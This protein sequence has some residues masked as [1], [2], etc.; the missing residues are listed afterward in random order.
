[1]RT[2]V[3][4]LRRAAIA[5][6]VATTAGFS[7]VSAHAAPADPH[8][9]G[10]TAV[11]QVGYRGYVFTV[12]TSWSVV[13]LTGA[14]HACVRFDRHV[15]YLGRPGAD[16]DCPGN[17]VGRTEALLVQPAVDGPGTGGAVAGRQA[18]EVDVAASRIDATATF[19]DDPALVLR[20][21]AGAGLPTA[22]PRAPGAVT[23]GRRSSVG[24]YAHASAPSAVPADA[25]NFTGKGFDACAAP[26]QAAMRAWTGASPYRAVGV[27]IGGS[28][29]ACDQPNLTA[30]WVRRQYNA[31]WRFL[32]LYVGEQASSISSAVDE[33]AAAADDAVAQARALG[34]G[35]GT[36]LYY[37]MEAYDPDCTANVLDF[38][39]AWTRELHAD[40]YHS[41]FYSSSH[42]GIDD[43]VAHSGDG[44]HTMPDVIF[45]ALW[46][47][48]ADTDDP[49]VPSGDWAGH[50]RVHQYHG[51]ISETWGG[52][53]QSVD[54]DLLD[55][56]LPDTVPAFGADAP[57]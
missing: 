3:E 15:L 44:V 20:V 53:E 5:A 19:G 18:H 2:A 50:R 54:Q 11:K 12:P 33:G 6:A 10:A 42:S 13:D 9:P 22:A 56:R 51:S 38:E 24:A 21:L 46:N 16:Q 8:R 48:S 34:F 39:T 17:V 28:D 43:L 47:G 30:S 49:S 55:V 57:A 4:G 32:P 25:T 41:G 37:D 26:S 35:P 29:R 27:Y 1:M 40:G 7:P 52:V 23:A 31:G 14:P 45:D 36:T